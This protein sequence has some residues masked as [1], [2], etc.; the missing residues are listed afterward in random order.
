MKIF[1]A[2]LALL[3]AS[4]ATAQVPASCRP[5]KLADVHLVS[6]G[7]DFAGWWHGDASKT[8][9]AWRG[10][11]RPAVTKD[12]AALA[13]A[14]AVM[15]DQR[16]FDQITT[17]QDTDSS[18]AA[19][20]AAVVADVAANKPQFVVAKNGTYPDRPAY[21]LVNGVRGTTSTGRATVGA[22]CD[23]SVSVMEGT[24]RYCRASGPLVAV[25]VPK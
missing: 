6:A 20:K 4:T 17:L 1:A 22:P 11:L 8:T 19:L 5:T 3:I 9:Y 23:C 13:Y 21:P 24:T 16:I 10:V 15:G 18:L 2:I 14:F 25:C 12:I 7:P